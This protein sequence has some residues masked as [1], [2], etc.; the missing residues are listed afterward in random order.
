MDSRFSPRALLSVVAI[1]PDATRYWV[2][3]SGGPDSHAL[4]H[5]LAAISSELPVTELRAIHVNHGLHPQAAQ[6]RGHCERVCERLA[7]ALDAIEVE[8]LRERGESLEA[9]AREARYAA[10]ERAIGPG[11]IVLTAH[12]E[13]DQAETLLLQL[14]RGAGPDGLAGMPV[15]A[16]LGPGWLARPLLHVSRAAV[17]AYGR[18]LEMGSVED[19]SNQDLRFDRN[20][21]RRELVPRLRSRWPSVGRTLA[22]AA[23]NQAQASALLAALAAADL[24]KVAGETP[25]TLS[26]TRLKSLDRARR[27]NVLRAWIK[28]RGFTVPSSAQLKQL[29]SDLLDAGPDRQ[30]LVHWYGCHA[31][32]YRDDF[33]VME[34]LAEFDPGVVHDWDLTHALNLPH[35]GLV[36][37]PAYGVGLAARHCD[38]GLVTVRFRHGGER[39]RPSGR[40][41]TQAL[42]RL[43]QEYSVPPWLRDRIP[44]IYVADELAAAAGLWVCERFAAGGADPGWQIHWQE[45]SACASAD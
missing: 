17:H 43:F 38:G 37:K 10:L 28:S 16:R 22:R 31:R 19:P 1:L 25:G 6:W 23:A 32:R 4:L 42:K 18:S 34:P 14:L 13:D 2:A 36:A 5:A 11:G 41:H 29:D 33:Y 3:F 45:R 35:G 30:P 26:C 21:L 8:V 27:A 15:L 39:C 20:F 40:R 44:L 24:E 9:A 12:T 7:I